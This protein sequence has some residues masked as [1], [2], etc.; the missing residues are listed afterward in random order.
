MFFNENF[1]QN[2]VKS[3]ES[4][5]LLFVIEPRLENICFLHM[6]KQRPRALSH[7]A[8][9]E[10]ISGCAIRNIVPAVAS[11]CRLCIKVLW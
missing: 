1:W 8:A 10:A 4:I 11:E 3:N 9:F 2:F 5:T 7:K 6:P